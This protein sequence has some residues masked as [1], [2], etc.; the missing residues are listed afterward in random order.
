[1]ICFAVVFSGAL[2]SFK[3]ADLALS[4]T[5]LDSPERL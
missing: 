4:D 3:H 1:M 2:L 5:N